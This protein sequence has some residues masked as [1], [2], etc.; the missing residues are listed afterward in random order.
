MSEQ[1]YIDAAKK[2]HSNNNLMSWAAQNLVFMIINT[3]RLK[4]AGMAPKI[5]AALK[6]C[7]K[8]DRS[9]VDPN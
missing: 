7:D 9:E 8:S 6:S 3:D 2:Y 5:S 1:A 4:I